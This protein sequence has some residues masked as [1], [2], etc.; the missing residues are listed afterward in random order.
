MNNL[1]L[2]GQPTKDTE[3]RYGSGT[4]NSRSSFKLTVDKGLYKNKKQEA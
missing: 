1:V 4:G 3:F 2:I